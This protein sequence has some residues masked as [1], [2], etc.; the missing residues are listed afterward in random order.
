MKKNA[1][2][3]IV[4]DQEGVRNLLLETCLILGYE[5]Q[6]TD[7][8]QEAL[9]LVKK[10]NYKIALIDMKMPGLDGFKTTQRI[11]KMTE[12]IRIV[13]ITGF[14]DNEDHLKEIRATHQVVAVMKKPFALEELK[15]ILAENITV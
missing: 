2:V 12:Q 8:G 7:S 10:N 11:M 15:E 14:D 5:A 1:Q 6:A 13:M 3:L 4:D 9:D